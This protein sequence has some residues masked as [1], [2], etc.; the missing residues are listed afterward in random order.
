[1]TIINI[2][3]NVN[4]KR[5]VNS[6][7]GGQNRDLLLGRFSNQEDLESFDNCVFLYGNREQGRAPT[8]LGRN[9]LH[10]K[11]PSDCFVIIFI[12][13]WRSESPKVTAESTLIDARL[14]PESFRMLS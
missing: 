1:M 12:T 6:R 4:M 7:M 10:T 3:I 9:G 13:I 5:K 8:G 2:Y 11:V 14:D